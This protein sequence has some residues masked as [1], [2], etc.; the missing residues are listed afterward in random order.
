MGKGRQ[1]FKKVQKGSKK[2]D[3]LHISQRKEWD[4]KGK[5]HVW[6]QLKQLAQGCTKAGFPIELVVLDEMQQ[7][8][9]NVAS[10]NNKPKS[11]AK[12]VKKRKHSEVSDN[13]NDAE[14]PS[15]NSVKDTITTEPTDSKDDTTDHIDPRI[16]NR[17]AA[18]RV[19]VTEC[20]KLANQKYSNKKYSS[21]G[22]RMFV[23]G[24]SG[25]PV[26]NRLREAKSLI[27][28]ISGYSCGV[29]DKV[30]RDDYKPSNCVAVHRELMR[31]GLR[32]SP[33][34]DDRIEPE[35]V[36]VHHRDSCEE[37]P[38][39]VDGKSQQWG[40]ELEQWLT[41][42]RLPKI[43]E[44]VRANH[45]KIPKEQTI[46]YTHYRGKGILDM[47]M[48][49]IRQPGLNGELISCESYAGGV[50]NRELSLERFKQGKVDVLVGTEAIATGTDGL[51]ECCCNLV[52][53]GLP[54]TAALWSQLLGR[55]H[56]TGQNKPVSVK[57]VRVVGVSKG[58]KDWA[59]IHLKR[60]VADAAVDGM[61]PLEEKSLKQYSI[62]YSDVTKEEIQKMRQENLQRVKQ[63]I[64]SNQRLQQIVNR[65]EQR[66]FVPSLKRV[67]LNELTFEC[68][69][70]ILSGSESDFDIDSLSDEEEDPG[71]KRAKRAQK[72]RKRADWERKRNKMTEE[73]REQC[74]QRRIERNT[75]YDRHFH[76]LQ[77]ADRH[78][79][80]QIEPHT[81]KHPRDIIW[82][83]YKIW[84]EKSRQNKGLQ[85]YMKEAPEQT[86][87]HMEYMNNADLQLKCVRFLFLHH[88]CINRESREEAKRLAR[89]EWTDK[90][91]EDGDLQNFTSCVEN[92]VKNHSDKKLFPSK[93]PPYWLKRVFKS[94][95]ESRGVQP[96][97]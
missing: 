41:K 34:L 73:E 4:Q 72:R 7:V 64:K 89:D 75:Q 5:E 9:V 43:I 57:I 24:L 42:V 15:Q 65:T 49:G 87:K 60:T 56:R 96:Q 19:L 83:G 17:V 55:L 35:I 92:H 88:L 62:K 3:E 2:W 11:A 46:V 53:N 71:K 6:D 67:K 8:K 47:L 82:N 76:A 74:K 80:K 32:I 33:H 25:T 78:F 85:N 48:D 30:F 18:V 94:F 63:D 31:W 90:F 10:L 14:E 81:I 54:Y 16:T 59:R 61:I 97:D 93:F 22:H 91:E 44:I 40:M 1:L 77:H 26:I 79:R 58:E 68:M 12:K 50:L 86:Q 45:A 70:S 84:K 69:Q 36:E 27:E 52:V 66:G 39:K 29:T 51:Q 23:L 37:P 20:R 38:P 21:S 95:R 28:L 13:S